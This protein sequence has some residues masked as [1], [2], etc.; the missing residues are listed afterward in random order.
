MKAKPMLTPTPN[1]MRKSVSMDSMPLP[2]PRVAALNEGRLKEEQ[3][4]GENLTLESLPSPVEKPRRPL[5]PETRLQPPSPEKDETEREKRLF[6]EVEARFLEV[7]AQRFGDSSPTT[8]AVMHPLN[9]SKNISRSIVPMM[10]KMFEKAKSCDPDVLSPKGDGTESSRSSFS[11]YQLHPG[12]HLHAHSV[13]PAASSQTISDCGS[14]A[15][16]TLQRSRSASKGSG[17]ITKLKTKIMGK[18]GEQ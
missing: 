13:S 5:N 2:G 4:E 12:S 3:E 18:A 6:K 8:P 10:R 1:S 17:L 15:S 9:R 11:Q 7:E 16:T 14:P